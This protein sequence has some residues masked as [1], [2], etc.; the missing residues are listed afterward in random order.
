MCIEC[1]RNPEDALRPLE[2]VFNLKYE[3][4]DYLKKNPSAAEHV[5]AYMKDNNLDLDIVKNDDA[6]Q[7]MGLMLK[8]HWKVQPKESCFTCHR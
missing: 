6:Q 1:H 4:A 8:D 3:A 2:Q 5:T 7:A